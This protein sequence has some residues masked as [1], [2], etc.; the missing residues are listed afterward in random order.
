MPHQSAL[1][2]SSDLFY[3]LFEHS[4]RAYVIADMFVR[5]VYG[6]GREGG[7]VIFFIARHSN[8]FWSLLVPSVILKVVAI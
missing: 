1:L 8:R 6:A 5:E 2:V 4:N 3:I 7:G